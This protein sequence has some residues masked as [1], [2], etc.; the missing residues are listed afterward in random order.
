LLHFF[1]R[2][3][4]RLAETPSRFPVGAAKVGK[5]FLISQQVAKFYFFFSSLRPFLVRNRSAK[6]GLKS[7]AAKGIIK[8]KRQYLYLAD[9]Q[10]ENFWPITPFPVA[11]PCIC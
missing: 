8:I 9:L 6:V 4:I 10:A 7:T 1:I 11:P 5:V 2:R 3:T